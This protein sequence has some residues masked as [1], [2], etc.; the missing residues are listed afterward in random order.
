MRG[1]NMQAWA[2]LCQDEKTALSLQF[3]MDKSSWQAGEIMNKSHYKYL[4]I[5]YRAEQF[6]KMFTEYYDNYNDLIPDYVE[7]KKSVM[8]YF[9]LC[10][11]KRQTTTQALKELGEKYPNVSRSSLNTAIVLQ[12]KTWENSNDIFQI[13]VFELVKEFD[14]WNN[15]RILPKEIQEPSAF[16]RRIKNLHKKNLKVF[17]RISPIA[18]E[19]IKKIYGAKRKPGY[20]LV[21]HIAENNYEVILTKEKSLKAISELGLYLFND[22]IIAE[23]YAKEIDLYISNQNRQCKDGLDF[24]PKYRELIKKAVNY[25]EIQKINSSRKLLEVA[26]SKFELL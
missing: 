6:L 3:G 19:K 16:K 20:F 22:S 4:E 15:F 18:F 2:V 25:E 23:E 10:I 5:K 14:R 13:A 1:V 21:L 24:W 7:G 26:A 8:D 9:R 12:L 11:E 17:K